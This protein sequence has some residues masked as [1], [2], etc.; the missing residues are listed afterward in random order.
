MAVDANVS[1]VLK[2]PSVKTRQGELSYRTSITLLY[3]KN[4]S[5]VGTHVSQAILFPDRDT[6]HHPGLFIQQKDLENE[7]RPKRFEAVESK[8]FTCIPI[9]LLSKSNNRKSRSKEYVESWSQH[10]AINQKSMWNHNFADE[11][12]QNFWEINKSQYAVCCTKIVDKKLPKART[13][14]ANPILFIAFNSSFD[15]LFYSLKRCSQG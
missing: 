11:H 7:Y 1:T 3:N 15:I 14:C 2:L 6:C 10:A 9:E 8:M 13:D 5:R 4:R 12:T